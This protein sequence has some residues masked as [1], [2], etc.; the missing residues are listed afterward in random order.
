MKIAFLWANWIP[1]I[2]INTNLFQRLYYLSETNEIHLLTPYSVEISP[3]IEDRVEIKRSPRVFKKIELLMYYIYLTRTI[4]NLKR[5]QFELI[6]T[7]RSILSIW[8]FLA[9]KIAGIKWVADIWDDPEKENYYLYKK[10]SFRWLMNK[11]KNVML[12]IILRY[13]DLVVCSILPEKI[14]SYKVKQKRI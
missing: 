3:K 12:K 1:D 7:E 8:G 11:L 6:I 5:D 2:S 10:L 4:F 9:K 14:R 13:S